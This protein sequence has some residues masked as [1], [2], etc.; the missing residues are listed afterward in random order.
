[1]AQTHKC[2][3]DDSGDEARGCKEVSRQ[4]AIAGGDEPEIFKAQMAF[5]TKCFFVGPLAVA[6]WLFAVGLAGDNAL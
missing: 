5:S 3:L 6:E 1:M 2:P 4:P